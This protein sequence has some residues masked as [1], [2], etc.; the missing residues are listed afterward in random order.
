VSSNP[1]A[2]RGSP[3]RR[4]WFL[5]L[6]VARE[7]VLQHPSWFE[8]DLIDIW[9]TVPASADDGPD[10]AARHFRTTIDIVNGAA[11][12]SPLYVDLPTA[13]TGQASRI[14]TGPGVGIRDAQQETSVSAPGVQAPPARHRLG[15]FIRRPSWRHLQ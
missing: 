9:S 6:P 2:Y 11:P 12:K 15:T 14:E 13:T 8:G 10:S 1:V 5:D 3:P 7:R 4:G